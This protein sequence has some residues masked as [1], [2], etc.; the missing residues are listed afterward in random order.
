[1]R[2]FWSSSLSFFFLSK[3]ISVKY[4]LSFFTL[5]VK[6]LESRQASMNKDDASINSTIEALIVKREAKRV[7]AQRAAAAAKKLKDFVV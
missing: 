6:L 7:E 5:L 1:M 2:P 3:M 4:L